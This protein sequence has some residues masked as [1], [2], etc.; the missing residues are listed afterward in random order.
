MAIY[1]AS[2]PVPLIAG[3]TATSAWQRGARELRCLV[4]R[5]ANGGERIGEI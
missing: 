3:L 4:L 2:V 5:E 1:C